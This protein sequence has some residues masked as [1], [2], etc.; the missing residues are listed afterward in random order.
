M[1]RRVRAQGSLNPILFVIA[2][3]LIVISAFLF[4]GYRAT[5]GVEKGEELVKHA[6]FTTS[7]QTD[8]EKISPNYGSVAQK[9]YSVPSEHET[10]CFVD[11]SSVS[12]DSPTL[13]NLPIIRDALLEGS[14]DNMFVFGEGFTYSSSVG[15][16]SF[17]HYPYVTCFDVS[18][19]TLELQLKGQG[20]STQLMAAF[21]VKEELPQPLR[22]D[23]LMK[24]VNGLSEL[25]L[26]KGTVVQPA[27]K[28]L[29]VEPIPKSDASSTHKFRLASEIF[30]FEPSIS[31]NPAAIIRISYFPHLL[32]PNVREE[33]IKIWYSNGDSWIALPTTVDTIK[34]IASAQVTHF[35]TFA[36][37]PGQSS[38]SR[39]V[40]PAAVAP[41][42]T[43]TVL[44]S[45]EIVNNEAYYAIEEPILNG[46][47]VVDKGGA[48]QAVGVLRWADYSA[49]K[50]AVQSTTLQYTL[51]APSSSG[52]YT[53]G[54]E[55]FVGESGAVA[56]YGDTEVVVSA[57]E[58]VSD[59]DCDDL[60]QC[61]TDQCQGG[62]CVYTPVD[63]MDD[64][65]CCP[66][67][68]TTQNDNDCGVALLTIEGKKVK[69]GDTFT[70]TVDIG[71]VENLYGF[72]FDLGYSN[73]I[74]RFVKVE[75]GSFLASGGVP[76]HCV[77]VES[78][79]G[80]IKNIACVRQGDVGGASGS[81]DL[82]RITFEAISAGNSPIS[83]Y[84]VQL[85]D[86]A[87]SAI[88]FKSSD[89]TVTVE[90][91]I[92]G[93]TV[94]LV[95]EKTVKVGDVF[96]VP[97]DV[98]DVNDLFGFQFDLSYDSSVLEFV[99]I[100]EGSFLNR[101][102]TV[103]TFC[104]DAEVTPGLIRNA[105][106]VVQEPTAGGASGSGTLMLVT[107]KALKKGATS[108]VLSNAL[109]SDSNSDPISF[110]A[111]DGKVTVTD[112]TGDPC[113]D[114]KCETSVD[115]SCANYG[116]CTA[117][118]C[119]GGCYDSGAM[120][121]EA[122]RVSGDGCSS[123]DGH[124]WTNDHHKHKLKITGLPK[125]GAYKVIFNGQFDG[126]SQIGEDL[127]VEVDSQIKD[128][129]D[130]NKDPGG[131]YDFTPGTVQLKQGTNYMFISHPFYDQEMADGLDDD[132]EG[133][134]IHYGT[135]KVTDC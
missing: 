1:L 58:C 16:I 131:W 117:S 114:G 82:I 80:M 116:D 99:S 12:S 127:R 81:G 10:V 6:A 65:G 98:S 13:Y 70:L 61:T 8:I 94:L 69:V 2:V 20:T 89:S 132:Y 11:T 28:E 9:S 45:V 60:D 50:S 71:Q 113:S 90:A 130:D 36:A 43:V 74:L 73:S 97:I 105:A 128:W 109:L 31:F 7:L 24:S 18:A 38:V 84:N 134:S 66:T 121:V 123:T 85:S 54:G 29:S 22:Y 25:S 110:T 64:D 14:R 3:G 21:V 47:T 26:S 106:C 46:W 23:F 87:A 129:W 55:Y 51:R 115:C 41:G 95:A 5:Q 120:A 88:R 4:L 112:G 33:D 92:P 100:E 72:Q 39:S 91:A 63:C 15:K 62:S 49:D 133:H 101:G 57:A 42:A 96:T 83:F 86:P 59:P 52:T 56:I 17:D 19:G 93:G 102:G 135:I 75:E 122:V 68:C 103:A 118:Q 44:L 78:T 53:F 76:T 37:G 77:D 48:T 30:S 27:V 35:T 79:P 107:F 108:L 126:P 34:K 104:I 124:C 32:P 111:N 67:G 119:A 40:Q 125:D